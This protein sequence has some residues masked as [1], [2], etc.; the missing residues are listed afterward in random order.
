MAEHGK[1]YQEVAKLIDAAKVYPSL[2]AIELAKKTSYSKFD[3]SVQVHLKMGVDPKASDQ[4]VRGIALLP[5]GLGKKVRVLVFAQGEA[6]KIAEE[7]GADFAGADDIVKKIE[8]GWTD[9]DVAVAT[10]DM[11]GKV[12]KLGKIL[13][14]KGLMPN[15]K[16]GTVAAAKDL[17]R[18][19]QDSRKGRVEFRLD[20]TGIIHAVIGK[21]SFE[22]NKLQENMTALMEAIIKAKPSRAKGQYVKTAYLS[23]TMGP[24]IRLDLK[25]V[26]ST[27]E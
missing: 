24:G 10:P 6:I 12:G 27:G 22:A 13:G 17:P 5:N 26:L 11:M 7:A 16:S 23:T 20:R 18:V 9:F 19:I 15:P 25:S 14:R 3:G 2:E 4:Q 21:V 8:D 1:K